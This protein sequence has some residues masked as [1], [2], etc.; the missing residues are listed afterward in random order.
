MKKNI[1]KQ[2]NKNGL[3]DII[4]LLPALIIFTVIV[5]YP[6][7]SS[8]RYSLTDWTFLGGNYN[9]IG[10]KNFIEI[11][12]N[13]LVI[14]GIKN[15]SIFVLYCTFLGN[16]LAL[17]L[18]IILDKNMKFKNYLKTV[19]YIPCLIST[20]IVS[21]VFGDI[22]QYHGILNE[23]FNKLGLSFLVNDWFSNIKT[24]LPMLIGLNSWQ[25]VGYGSIIYL[26]GLQTIP[27]EYYEAAKIDG[28]G[29]FEI[30]KQITLPLL[31]PSITIMTFMS[32]TGGFKLFDIPYVM[33]NGGPGMATETMCTAI[34]RLA[35][36]QRRF[37]LATAVSVVFFFAIAIFSVLQVNFTRKK[38]VQM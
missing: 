6:L 5:Y 12:R 22:L 26:A 21:A 23:L 25:F 4:F 27:N 19:F 11:F 8:F 35:F 38:E 33:T 36:S 28:A 29:G 15:T 7:I 9:F 30:F 1:L 32:I 10:F 14:A 37:G 3:I 34:Y 24:A 17:L 13:D 18:A 31:M 20:I 16:T 2:K